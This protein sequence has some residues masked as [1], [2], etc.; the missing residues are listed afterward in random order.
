[1]VFARVMTE[2]SNSSVNIDCSSVGEFIN[3][4]LLSKIGST[5]SVINSDV[6]LL[7]LAVTHSSDVA[8]RCVTETVGGS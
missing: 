1:V 8:D 7:L 4:F 3:Q 6:C 2:T 5:C